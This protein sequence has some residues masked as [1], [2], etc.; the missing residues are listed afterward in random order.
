MTRAS[1]SSWKSAD[2][3]AGGGTGCRLKKADV[4]RDVFPAQISVERLQLDQACAVC[5][6]DFSEDVS[7]NRTWESS[8]SRRASSPEA[9]CSDGSSS[10]LFSDDLSSGSG[11][12][13]T[14]SSSDLGSSTE[15][16]P[17]G[18]ISGCVHSF[19]HVCIQN[20][21]FQQNTCPQC[22]RRFSWL[23][24]YSRE[25]CRMKVTYVRNRNLKVDGPVVSAFSDGAVCPVCLDTIEN[26]GGV[27]SCDGCSA[28]HHLACAGAP[29]N[30]SELLNGLWFC[31][32]CVCEEMCVD[33]E[34]QPI[35]ASRLTFWGFYETGR[36]RRLRRASAASR[37]PASQNSN[38]Q[39]S[40]RARRLAGRLVRSSSHAHSATS[41]SN[42]DTLDEVLDRS[43]REAQEAW[44]QYHSG[45]GAA[46][47]E[48]LPG[49]AGTAA[50][51]FL[52]EAQGV[53]ANSISCRRECD[54]ALHVSSAYPLDEEQ[55]S[56][57]GAV[58]AASRAT[59][60]A[61]V[62]GPPSASDSPTA[63]EQG[64]IP[65]HLSN[66]A[67]CHQSEPV[68]VRL[69]LSPA[70]S[71]DIT[72]EEAALSIVDPRVVTD[73][74]VEPDALPEEN[75]V[76]VETRDQSCTVSMTRRIPTETSAEKAW[77]SDKNA[78]GKASTAGRSG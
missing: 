63:S 1:P 34:G 48:S 32:K 77:R 7:E 35:S 29:V 61:D 9:S 60:Q 78:N 70:A 22:K 27:I 55:S 67:R 62:C 53:S 13:E 54:G 11:A 65:D 46:A 18:L 74:G 44:Q 2:P 72:S 40:S 30:R 31:Q 71:A 52:E 17:L 37:F 33:R 59:L 57:D 38:H 69:V 49:S 6:G 26:G 58:L 76:S 50:D 41:R 36:R 45:A 51:E 16:A 15:L 24:C 4:L 12:A 19:H 10:S 73:A 39:V 20:W 68:C 75:T 23:A 56:A 64:Q 47:R 21:G 25:G 66:S 14:S 5:Q 8:L 3:L 43:L 28:F 42:H